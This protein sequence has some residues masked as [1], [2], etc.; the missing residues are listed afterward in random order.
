M[1]YNDVAEE[2]TAAM[3]IDFSKWLA[4]LLQD[5][6]LISNQPKLIS[7]T[8][9]AKSIFY[10]LSNNI[11]N[12]NKFSN[13]TWTEKCQNTGSLNSLQTLHLIFMT[14]G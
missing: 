8:K 10:R 1:H 3:K 9:N 14:L 5:F 2:F 7:K 11:H 12:R 13:R 6:K 4:F